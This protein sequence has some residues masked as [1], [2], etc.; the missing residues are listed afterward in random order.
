MTNAAITTPIENA[1]G[2][3]LG[4]IPRMGR[5]MTDPLHKFD[6]RTVWFRLDANSPDKAQIMTIHRDGDWC[7][8]L[9]TIPAS[10]IVAA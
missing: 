1:P 8:L 2:F 3:T 9:H 10:V 4:F 6:G 5:A 7:G